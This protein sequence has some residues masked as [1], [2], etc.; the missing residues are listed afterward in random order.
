MIVRFDQRFRRDEAARALLPIRV[1]ITLPFSESLAP[2]DHD[3]LAVFE[4]QLEDLA[5]LRIG[6]ELVV[7][8]TTR[9]FREFVLHASTAEGIAALHGELRERHPTLDVQMFAEHD[10]AWDSYFTITHA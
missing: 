6:V 8:I 9:D 4:D 10:A 2:G 5:R 1:G 3:R 7:V